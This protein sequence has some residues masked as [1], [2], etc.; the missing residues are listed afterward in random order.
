[1]PREHCF[2]FIY[3][4]QLP[5]KFFPSSVLGKKSAHTEEESSH[6]WEGSPHMGEEVTCSRFNR[7]QTSENCHSYKVPFS[8]IK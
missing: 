2:K 4:K 8:T 3:Q 6:N 5:H 7:G 1:M